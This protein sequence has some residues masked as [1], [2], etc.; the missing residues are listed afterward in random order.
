MGLLTKRIDYLERSEKRRSS[1]LNELEASLET[2]GE[3]L[4]VDAIMATQSQ[5]R[6][7]RLFT[8]NILNTLEHIRKVSENAKMWLTNISEQLYSHLDETKPMGRP[9]GNHPTRTTSTM[10]EVGD[11]NKLKQQAEV[12]LAL[13]VASQSSDERKNALSVIDTLIETLNKHITILDMRHDTTKSAELRSLKDFVLK[14]KTTQLQDAGNLVSQSDVSSFDD[15]LFSF[16]D[17]LSKLDSMPKMTHSWNPNDPNALSAVNVT[18]ANGQIA[19][20]NQ[21][22]SSSSSS[23][24]NQPVLNADETA[25]G[26]FKETEELRCDLASSRIALEKHKVQ[27][28]NDVSAQNLIDRITDIQEHLVEVQYQLKTK[29]LPSAQAP[30]AQ[31]YMSANILPAQEV[32]YIAP[33]HNFIQ[34]HTAPQQ[35]Q[36]QIYAAQNAYP[37]HQGQ[38]AMH[39]AQQVNLQPS[40]N[41]PQM[42]QPPSQP[43]Y[44]APQQQPIQMVPQQPVYNPPPH[45]LGHMVYRRPLDDEFEL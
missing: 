34:H 6:G 44:A 43:V 11:L 35:H 41:H 4:Q 17:T 38:P 22:S 25:R 14:S 16:L 30:S 45:Q 23:A 33:T 9:G 13:L 15:R 19:L 28:P 21:A 3:V 36:G 7:P 39:Q 20:N 24:N 2:F 27:H 18:I 26:L 37:P 12:S 40:Y 1:I 10:G 8:D 32:P 31:P 42:I 5:G 29:Y